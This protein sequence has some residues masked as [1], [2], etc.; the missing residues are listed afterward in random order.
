MFRIWG[1]VMKDT[2]FQQD[3]VVE[4]KDF[5]MT[6]DDKIMESLDQCC[7]AFDLQKPMWFDKNT[8]EMKQ[9]A[10]TSFHADQFIEL[11]EFDYF[12]I[13]IIEDDFKKLK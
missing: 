7:M 9:F 4:I 13:E 12:E 2:K 10:K 1:K 8:K 6:R 3:M 5:N 11:I